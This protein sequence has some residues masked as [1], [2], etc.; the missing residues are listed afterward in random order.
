ME[1]LFFFSLPSSSIM[2]SILF[3]A[4]FCALFALIAADCNTA[5]KSEDECYSPKDKGECCM[6]CEGTAGASCT[7]TPT[8]GLGL[9][10]AATTAAVKVANATALGC[11]ATHM[12]E[13]Y[14][15]CKTATGSA[16]YA[17]VAV[18]VV[19]LAVALY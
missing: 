1:L 2:R 18:G 14:C 7:P 13:G 4:V 5:A 10:T 19:A 15:N 17:S 11:D 3:V 16:L 6:Y 8:A 12:A 9:C